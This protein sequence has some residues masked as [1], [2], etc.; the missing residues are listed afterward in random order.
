MTKLTVLKNSSPPPKKAPRPLTPGHYALIDMLAR[1][2]AKDW[3][4]QQ[5]KDDESSDLREV[6]Q[7]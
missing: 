1:Q 7:R 4:A 3:L 5:E 6:Q 2:A